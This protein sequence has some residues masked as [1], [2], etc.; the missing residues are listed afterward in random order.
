MS[1]SGSGSSAETAARH[2]I[3]VLN[4]ESGTVVRLG[5]EHIIETLNEA[6]ADSD[7][8]ISIRCVKAREVQQQLEE[9]AQSDA[10]AVIVGGGDGTVASA[11]TILAKY[12]KA[13]GVLP[14]GTFNLAARDLGMP[15]D[16]TAAARALSHAPVVPMDAMELN[17]KLYLCL[18]VMGFY[19]A[20]MLSQPEYHGWWIVK[21]L[22]TLRDSLRHAATFPALDL[23][24]VQKDETV[25]CRT[26]VA[27]IANNDYQEI[28]G[29]IPQRATLDA[30]YFSVYLSTHRTR[31]GMLRSLFAWVLGRWKEDR[32]VKRVQATELEIHAKRKRNLPVMMDG[33][34]ERLPLPLRITL[35]PGILKVLSP[36]VL[37]E[38][39][40]ISA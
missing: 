14:L 2:F 22:R 27:L 6:F 4:Q 8:R 1:N 12:D 36:R 24:L 30:G 38:P 25:Q 16:L 28:F 20:L 5:Q 35:R 39:E 15:L 7:T 33:E 18:V 40:V 26:R 32:E 11:A 34:I 9:A 10:D 21:A 17:G 37:Q 13:M 29:V 19:P 3:V 31:L 23:T